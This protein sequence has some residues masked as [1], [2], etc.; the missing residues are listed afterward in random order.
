MRI[1]S[2]DWDSSNII[3][4]AKN[5][6]NKDNPKD[7]YISIA[8]H[9]TTFSGKLVFATILRRVIS[10]S[11]KVVGYVI[12]DVYSDAISSNVNTSSIFQEELL[13]DNTSYMAIS[14]LHPSQYGSFSIFPNLYG[15]SFITIEKQIPDSNFSVIAN[16]DIRPYKTNISSSM[17]FL[18]FAIIIG[19]VISV[20]LALIF[21]HSFAKRAKML[22]DTMSKVEE[23]KLDVRSSQH[24][25]IEEFDQLAKAFNKMTVEIASLIAL[26]REEEAKLAEAERK[27]LEDQLNPHFLFNT[28][29]TIK[30]LA[31][32]H[33]E[34]Q[35]YTIS[36]KLGKILRSSLNSRDSECTIEESMDLVESY[37]MIQ[38]IR[39][40]DKISYTLDVDPTILSEM[41]PKLI[42]QPLVENAIIHALEPKTESGI[43]EV[44]IKDRGDRISIE[45][46]DDGVG[47]EPIGLEELSKGGHVGLYNVYRRLELRYSD[48]LSFSIDS[49]KGKG[50]II[51]ISFPK[52]GKE[53][54]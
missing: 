6:E 47:F 15:E 14:L 30:A 11:G 21:S 10:E 29:N 3:V 1:Y 16:T 45:V 48:S 22:T 26:T 52:E 20:M 51:S 53:N 31:R 33:G 28:L 18:A 34:N 17:F 12:I 8:D 23:G 43:V 35:I 27:E 42:I 5:A 40:K 9:R 24:T 46:R 36:I 50:T 7:V 2:N 32:L 37:L 38:K 54:R 13:V 19:L 25:G 4:R 49:K 41:T 39:F 44:H